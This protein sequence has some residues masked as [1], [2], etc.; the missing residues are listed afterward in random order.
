MLD[1]HGPQAFGGGVDRGG[2][3]G[4]PEPITATSKTAPSGIGRHQAECVSDL[5]V[6]GVDQRW[7][8][9]PE[10]EYDNRQFRGLQAEFVQHL[11]AKR[12]GGVIKAGRDPMAGE[13]VTQLLETA[14]TTARQ[15]PT[16]PR[17]R[18]PAGCS[19]P[20]GTR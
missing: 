20:A 16:P 4:R 2:E 17:S 15:S 1:H 14:P 12:G 13:K 6:G 10:R 9:S 7:P 5:P 3:P 8:L 18:R 11:P 19:I